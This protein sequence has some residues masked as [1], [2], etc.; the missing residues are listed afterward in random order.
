MPTKASAMLSVS[1]WRAKRHG[2]APSAVRTAN[3]RARA[4]ARANKSPATF[5]QA[6]SRTKP[7]APRRIS[8]GVRTSPYTNSVKGMANKLQPEALG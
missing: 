1:I 2:E 4:D 7:T 5:E 8:N 6:I 3:S